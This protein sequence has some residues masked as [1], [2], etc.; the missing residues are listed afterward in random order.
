[1]SL[2]RRLVLPSVALLMAA[3]AAACGSD[4]AP[5]NAST[6]DFCEGQ[7]SLMA[8]LSADMENVPEPKEIAESIQS[9]ADEVEEIGTPEDMSE[10]ARAGFEATLEQARDIEASDLETDNLDELGEELTGDAKKEAEAFNEYV[11][12]TCGNLFEDLELPE[13]PELPET[14]E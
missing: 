5:T 7:G 4:D 6:E 1:M 9:W 11:A 12:E 3:T 13:V 2:R 8:D 14:T 10:E